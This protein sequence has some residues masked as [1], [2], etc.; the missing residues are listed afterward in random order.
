MTGEMIRV[1]NEPVVADFNAF[2]FILSG[3]TEEDCKSLMSCFWTQFKTGILQGCE[4]GT[5]CMY[6]VL[7]FDTNQHLYKLL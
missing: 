7:K 1:W 4:A 5:N 2:H 3:G 6:K